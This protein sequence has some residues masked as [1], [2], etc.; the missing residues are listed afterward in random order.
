M[1]EIREVRKIIEHLIIECSKYDEQR[2]RQIGYIV[3]NDGVQEWQRKL[4]DENVGTSR[5]PGLYRGTNKL[6]K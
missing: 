3:P 1:L 4:G 2:R 6:R 5:V